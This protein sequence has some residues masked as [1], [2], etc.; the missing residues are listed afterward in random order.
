M[1]IGR[2][3][4]RFFATTAAVV[5]GFLYILFVVFFVFGVKKCYTFGLVV[6]LILSLPIFQYGF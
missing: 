5:V 3:T 2:T 4:F 6:K 1:V